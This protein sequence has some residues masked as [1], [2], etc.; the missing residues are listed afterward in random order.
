MNM[1]TILGLEG[2]LGILKVTIF[3]CIMFELFIFFFG[4]LS[5]LKF[6]S[7]PDILTADCFVLI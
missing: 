5:H 1:F 7:F 4:D 3:N 2:S 6:I